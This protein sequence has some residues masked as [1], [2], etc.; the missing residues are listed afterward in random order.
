MRWRVA[1]W[2]SHV[3]S[4]PRRDTQLAELNGSQLPDP[5]RVSAA[6]TGS[7]AEPGAPAAE[8]PTSRSLPDALCQRGANEHQS[9]SDPAHRGTPHPRHRESLSPVPCSH[10]MDRSP[11]ARAAQL[12][13]HIRSGGRSQNIPGTA[14]VTNAHRDR[15][16]DLA[17]RL[18]RR[19]Q[20]PIS[21]R[22]RS[23]VD[24]KR[25]SRQ[26][27]RPRAS[28]PGAP[29]RAVDQHCRHR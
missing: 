7:F 11:L 9:P 1:T 10:P 26:H 21:S 13:S 15:P 29:R 16:A 12:L 19:N 14:R 17:R 22:T 23:V 8:H 4:A 18:H 6:A 5:R 2:R 25:I 28:C 27:P 3:R 20:G 24:R